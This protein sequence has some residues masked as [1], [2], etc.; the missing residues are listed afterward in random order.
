[1]I[2]RNRKILIS[3]LIFLTGIICFIFTLEAVNSQKIAFGIKVANFNLG[4]QTL[5]VSQEILKDKWDTYANSEIV[6]HYQNR[7]WA[8]KL[9]DL[10]F[11]INYQ[12][13]ANQAYQ[14]T[15]QSNDLI[16]L[17]DQL[18]ALVGFYNLSLIYVVD[19]QRFESRTAEIF[20]NIEQ[21][22]KD[23]TLIFD[24][25]TDQFILQESN[26][27]S[28]ID[29]EKLLND[30]SN[31]IKVFSNQSISLNLIN[32]YPEVEDNEVDAVFKKAN[33]ILEG[34][35][36][37]LD[38]EERHWTIKK[39]VLV[40]WIKFEAIEQENSNNQILD[41]SL[42]RA[43]MREY[44]K[45]YVASIIDRPKTNARLKIEDNKATLFIPEQDGFEV[46]M[47]RTLDQLTE[48][49]LGGPPI[50]K[51]NV[52]ASRSRPKIK[53]WQTNNL[54]INTLIAQG[55]SNF[56]GSP[57]N[58]VHN[59]K[60]GIAKLN[61]IILN[62]GQEFSFNTLLG[63]SGPEQGYLPELVIKKGKVIP[64]YGGGLC[65]V[66]TTFFRAAINS[67][68]Q[69]TERYAHA[70]PVA[71]YAPHGF[72]A[73]V[74]DPRPDLRFVNNT[75]AHILLQAVV[76]GNQLTIN[77]YGTDDGRE[78]RIEGP[79][80]MLSRPNG[81]MKTVLTQ[82]VYL[83]DEII[84]EQVFYSNYNSPDLYTNNTNDSE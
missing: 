74:Y 21:L 55:V 71:Y 29:R 70:F 31:R 46:K 10:G 63:D 30:L 22:A 33:Q 3:V 48:N 78:V 67:G 80:I 61:G 72:D 49:I 75:S 83:E 82:R 73:T 40:D 77:V 51:T 69:I 34:H 79:Y 59:I 66:S 64:E 62:P 68:L 41:L 5:K 50:Q 18:A 58:R 7:A 35:P 19:E 27:G 4:N 1:M 38:F 44:L 81:S 76:E 54:G 14:I 52:T 36:F 53:L 11:Q 47:D 17:K 9:A 37:R 39:E 60:T 42:D 15:R 24:Q 65:Q 25:E 2:E 16:N 45:K 28:A 13:T 32:D 43:K 12:T 20:Q 8:I 84:E 56:A 57:N 26:K 23:A 6:L